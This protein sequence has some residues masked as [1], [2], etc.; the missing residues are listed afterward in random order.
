MK[1]KL[2]KKVPG[3]TE[4]KKQ[5]RSHVQQQQPSIPLKVLVNERFVAK[6]SVQGT[7]DAA[8]WQTARNVV[9]SLLKAR[10]G[11]K[12]IHKVQLFALN[13][14]QTIRCNLNDFRKAV[15]TVLQALYGLIPQT[16]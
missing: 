4:N 7:H 10:T 3:L 14:G 16:A 1:E 9:V 2:R 11:K 13:V 15:R 5:P 12:S 6:V 8:L